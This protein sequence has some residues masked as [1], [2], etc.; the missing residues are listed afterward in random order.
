LTE[1]VA[2]HRWGLGAQK[3]QIHLHRTTGARQQKIKDLLESRPFFVDLYLYKM[4]KIKEHKEIV[5]Q[6]QKSKGSFSNRPTFNQLVQWTKEESSTEDVEKM[7]F[8]E[9]LQRLLDKRKDM[10]HMKHQ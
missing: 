5:K 3:L 2:P 7:S 1:R 6:I 8:K 10:K 4:H 9:G